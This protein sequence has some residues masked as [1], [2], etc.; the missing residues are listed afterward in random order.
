MQRDDQFLA[1]NIVQQI[2]TELSGAATEKEKVALITKA[3]F[4][5]LN[6][7]ANDSSYA[8]E[9]HSSQC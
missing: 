5:L 1:F 2:M 4:R 3:V 7:S 6:V 8:S 9:N